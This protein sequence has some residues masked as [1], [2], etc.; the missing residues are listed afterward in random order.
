MT[1]VYAIIVYL[2]SGTQRLWLG[3]GASSLACWRQARLD[4]PFL[5]GWPAGER[6]LQSRIARGSVHDAPHPTSWLTPNGSLDTAYVQGDYP[7][8]FVHSTVMWTRRPYAPYYQRKD[9]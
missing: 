5:L 4:A 9:Q 8:A 6:V 1:I 2:H 7:P 3:K